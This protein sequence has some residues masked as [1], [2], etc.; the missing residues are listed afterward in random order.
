MMIRHTKWHNVVH[1]DNCIV[2][3]SLGWDLPLLCRNE[4]KPLT[5]VIIIDYDI[6]IISRNFLQPLRRV[7]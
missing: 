6:Y 1:M 4:W 2:V 7:F 3:E 5:Q